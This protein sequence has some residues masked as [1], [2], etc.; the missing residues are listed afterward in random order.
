MSRGEFLERKF[1]KILLSW[2]AQSFTRKLDE[3]ALSAP[4]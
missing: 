4:L 2:Q 3:G 1:Q